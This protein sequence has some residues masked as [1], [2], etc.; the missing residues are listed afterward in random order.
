[1]SIRH[2]FI[3]MIILIALIFLGLILIISQLV[4]NSSF[5]EVEINSIN[6][7]MERIDDAVQNSIKDLEPTIKDWGFWDDTY[8]FVN[9]HNSSYQQNNL[10]DLT[11]TNLSLNLFVIYDKDFKVVIGKE[12]DLTAGTLQPLS[13]AMEST[14]LLVKPLV[15]TLRYTSQASG[16]LK[17][18]IEPLGFAICPI[19]KSDRSGPV[20]GYILMGRFLSGEYV[21]KLPA[22][23][24]IDINIW[25]VFPHSVLPD[26]ANLVLVNH[27]KQKTIEFLPKNHIAAW[28]I[29]NDLNGKPV[30]VFKVNAK[31]EA[32][33][34]GNRLSL[35]MMLLFILSAMSQSFIL[36]KLIDK[37]VLDR[38]LKVQEQ[39]LT[40]AK[41]KDHKGMID[42]SGDD[43]ITILSQQINQMLL[44]LRKAISVKNEFLTHMSH[45]IRTPLNGIIGMGNLLARTELD[46]DQREYVNSVLI[47]GESLLT[48]INSILDFSKLE[49]YSTELVICAFDL[50][51]C[52]DNVITILKGKASEKSISLTYDVSPDIS[53]MVIGD[54]LRLKQIL[55]NLVGNALKFTIKGKIH[56]VV[57]LSPKAGFLVWTLT[58]TGI[59]IE[60]ENINKI[61]DPFV[62][63][64]SSMTKSYGG[65]GLGLAITHKLVL[66]MQGEISIDSSVGK[67]T[68]ITFTTYMP[69]HADSAEPDITLQSTNTAAAMDNH[70]GS[71]QQMQPKEIGLHDQPFLKPMLLN[72][73]HEHPMQILVAEDNPVNQKMMTMLF[74]KLGYIPFVAENGKIAL[75]VLKEQPIDI[76]FLDIQM[77]VMDGFETAQHILSHPE[78]YGSPIIIALTAN[79]MADDREKCLQ[80]GM[81]DYLPKPVSFSSVQQKIIAYHG[82]PKTT[83]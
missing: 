47:S 55:I 27:A 65:S 57:S 35:W 11:M 38:L 39:V 58:D 19:L 82:S 10:N 3:L 32:T 2:R 28:D 26:A 20:N 51:N 41:T 49:Y 44:S 64:D 9:D 34:V 17:T 8:F 81:H 77:P 59:G 12:H 53:K 33:R 13:P 1:M 75:E 78:I 23:K 50:R 25:T 66:M 15:D 43:E 63:A 73:A 36:Y 79:A 62:Q 16:I 67:G 29:I 76:I 4:I 31:R 69:Q 61:F 74:K 40:V 14:L 70:T 42:I 52:L 83:G 80:A 68:Q 71:D 54:E 45:E 7:K 37:R 46:A 48:L 18:V 72:I 6:G 24:G 60:S 30:F 22:L 56:L 5:K 21:K